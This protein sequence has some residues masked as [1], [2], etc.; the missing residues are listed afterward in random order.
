MRIWSRLNTYLRE[1]N[2]FIFFLILLSAIFTA[3][4][5]LLSVSFS[6]QVDSNNLTQEALIFQRGLQ[7]EIAEQEVQFSTLATALKDTQAENFNELS[8]QTF[9]VNP[10]LAKIELRDESGKLINSVFSPAGKL[11]SEP[12]LDRILPPAAAFIFSKAVEQQKSYW[13]LRLGTSGKIFLLLIAPSGEKNHFL[14]AYIDAHHLIEAN[15]RKQLPATIQVA[16]RETPESEIKSSS[17]VVLSMGLTGL[18]LQLT[19]KPTGSRHEGG[20]PSS[21]FIILLG[22]SLVILLIRFNKEITSS[23]KSRNQLDIQEKA[24]AKQAQLSTLGEISTTL[25][26][27][28]NQPLAT[29]TNYIATC[30][31]RLRQ[32]GI[33]DPQL[34]KALSDARGQALRAADIVVSIRKFLQ[35]G[36]STKTKVEI[37]RSISDLMPILKSLIK[38]KRAALTLR[39]EPQL[40]IYFDAALF[41]QILFNI[42]RNGLDA[43][44]DTPFELRKLTIRTRRVQLE[45]GNFYV[46]IDVE[47]AGHGISSSDAPKIFMPFFTTKSEGMGIG[48][49]LVKSL[50]ERHGG[51]IFWQANTDRGVTFTIQFPQYTNPI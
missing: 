9:L 45:N 26:H 10:H 47:D 43:M 14:I 28:L 16:I 5:L 19:F 25:A 40:F 11:I 2:A 46:Q 18:N 21:I 41:E 17:T 51:R 31:I 27:E 24:L 48:L 29:I 34:E 50:T 4:A 1:G 12:Y 33:G 15:A 38:E 22:L 3:Y 35:K 37:E 6:E 32:L 7:E 49:S 23:K 39:S 8:Y 20:N 13:A 30:E 44:A 36:S 42:C